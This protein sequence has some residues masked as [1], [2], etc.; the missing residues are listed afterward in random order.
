MTPRKRTISIGN[1][2]TL[3]TILVA[4]DCL[5]EYKHRTGIDTFDET[6]LLLQEEVEGL[7]EQTDRALMVARKNNT[8]S[9]LP[10]RK[11]GRR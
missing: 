7:A 6:V 1:L 5:E 4:M 9:M 11:R 2:S 3:E 8:G 10:N